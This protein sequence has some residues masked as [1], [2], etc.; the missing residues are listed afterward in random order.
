MSFRNGEIVGDYEVVSELG[1]GGMGCVYKVRNTLSN[2]VEAMKVLLPLSLGTAEQSERFLREIRVQASLNHPNIAALRTALRVGDQVV[3]IMELV[4]G[5]SLQAMQEAGPI[6]PRSAVDYI[7]QTLSALSYAHEHGVVHRDIKPAN[8]LLTLDGT[9]KIT[10]FGIAKAGTDR[11]LTSSGAAIGSLYYMSPE[12]VK[13]SAVD[14]RTDIYSVGVTL[15]ELLTRERPFQ[16][17]QNYEVMTTLV[18]EPPIPPHARNPAIPLE[19]SQAILKALAKDPDDRFQ[20]AADF[21]EALVKIPGVPEQAAGA[22]EATEAPATPVPGT[23][24]SRARATERASTTTLEMAY[25]LFMDIVAY[26]TLTMDRQTERISTLVEVVRDTD[27]F[28]RAQA[29]DQIISLPTGDGMALVFFQ[30]PLAPVQCAT[31]ISRALRSHSEIKL[32]MG[33]HTGPVYRIADINTNRNVAG[34]GINVA[35]RV[36]DCGDAGHIL[37]SKTVADTLGQLS[38]WS[39]CFHD[40][41][42]VEVK[43]GVKIHIVNYCTPEVGNPE[44]PQ[45]VRKTAIPG[46]QAT[47]PASSAGPKPAVVPAPGP[48]VS[49]GQGIAAPTPP[50]PTPVP[51]PRSTRKGLWV[52]VVVVAVVLVVAAAARFLHRTTAGTAGSSVSHASVVPPTHSSPP[53]AT[54][55]SS[56]PPNA[57]TPAAAMPPAASPAR[58]TK[59]S[60]APA[61]TAAARQAPVKHHVA[62]ARKSAA[63]PPAASPSSPPTQT[64]ASVDEAQL[65]GLQDRLIQLNGRAEA[66]RASLETMQREQ[67]AAGLSLR[68]DMVAA[69]Q[70]MDE[71]LDEAQK[72]LA[73]GDAS[74]AKRNLDMAERQVEK[75]ENFLG[76]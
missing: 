36:M 45:K 48:Q 5:K 63:E 28:Q 24:A 22:S 51:V 47:A 44:L 52:G 15:Y 35:Q 59:H 46:V 34:G 65:Q 21:R 57:T 1:R 64:S 25:V 17:N 61:K 10:D 19:L 23:A 29:N 73:A 62:A 18:N 55:P 27:E 14:A 6:P 67:N 41:G 13:G 40:L 30:N 76:R 4:E 69:K 2:R 42:E 49:P 60:E 3:M 50:V 58:K 54:P 72:A 53:S 43:H 7:C 70:T 11:S 56:P 32:R 37:V 26:S 74:S 71:S 39:N 38:D 8:I 66:V 75:L 20:T 31:E 68:G 16:G 33:V 12:Q 9:V